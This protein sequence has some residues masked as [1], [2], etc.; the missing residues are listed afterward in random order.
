MPDNAENCI[1][2]REELRFEDAVA[3]EVT[4]GKCG[5]PLPALDIA[6]RTVKFR[7]EGIDKTAL[8]CNFPTTKNITVIRISWN[9]HVQLPV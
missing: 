8:Y 6:K 1:W 9:S 3:T 4:G 5:I 7:A 2:F